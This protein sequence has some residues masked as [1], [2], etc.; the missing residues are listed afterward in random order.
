MRTYRW[1]DVRP[2]TRADDA[3]E[4]VRRAIAA[5]V[6]PEFVVTVEPENPF[7]PDDPYWFVWIKE[8]GLLTTAQFTD[9]FE[10]EARVRIATA[11]NVPDD[12]FDLTV[13][14]NPQDQ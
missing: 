3:R 1:E 12:S 4:Q 11:L 5:G 6:R 14:Q 13:E 8:L 9:E 7:A 10:P 2:R